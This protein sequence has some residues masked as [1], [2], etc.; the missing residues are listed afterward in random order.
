MTRKQ[1]LITA[2]L[3]TLLVSGILLTNFSFAWINADQKTGQLKFQTGN[4]K[5]EVEGF[6][7]RRQVDSN[8]LTFTDAGPNLSAFQI[9]STTGQLLFTFDEANSTVFQ[10]LNLIDLYRDQHSLNMNKIPS[11][12]VELQLFANIPVAYY[13]I[14]MKKMVLASGEP[15]PTFNNFSFRYTVVANNPSAPIAYATPAPFGISTL[16]E[17]GLT[18][19]QTGITNDNPLLN[20]LGVYNES[21]GRVIGEGTSGQVTLNVPSQDVAFYTNN[22]VK[23]VVIE[24][25]PD[26]LAFYR[27]LIANYQTL[28]S[29]VLMGL[30][31][32]FDLNF[33]LNSFGGS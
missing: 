6:M 25:T 7:F 18:N 22:F 14:V 26:P 8:N 28:N 16:K 13:Q 24:I 32:S 17:T 5:S 21:T 30:K 31:L 3:L 2:N 29:G 23:S 10:N 11:Y 4:E 27:F 15:V 33:S 19:I 1:K 20:N 9:S 12:F